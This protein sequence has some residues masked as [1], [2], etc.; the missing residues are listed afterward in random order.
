MIGRVNTGGGGSYK[1][2]IRASGDPG[3]SV[4][5]V[6]KAT[7]K[8]M[9]TGTIGQDGTLTLTVRQGGTYTVTAVQG[10]QRK[11]GDV[12]VIEAGGTYPVDVTF[13]DGTIFPGNEVGNRVTGGWGT[14][15]AS[16][17]IATV[18]EDMITLKGG[19]SSTANFAYPNNAIDLTE[20][21][22]IE[23]EVDT[24]ASAGW[25][26][27]SQ[28]KEEKYGDTGEKKSF[29]V[30]STS[31][32]RTTYQLDIDDLNQELYINFYSRQANTTMHIYRVS[33]LKSTGEAKDLQTTAELV[34]MVYENDLEV[35]G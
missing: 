9:A 5:V 6:L 33:L 1:A 29:N 14:K 3:A 7:G 19:S 30:P 2:F 13:W 25:I 26:C 17:G 12:V 20:F 8:T 31:E 11:T 21:S 32:S 28:N 23:F 4:T 34:D 27:V 10:S 22:Y 35:I 24:N 18:V 16:G 15:Q